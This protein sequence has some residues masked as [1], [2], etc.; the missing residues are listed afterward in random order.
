M[1]LAVSSVS[2]NSKNFASVIP[3]RFPVPS[4]VVKRQTACGLLLPSLEAPALRVPTVHL[5]VAVVVEDTA[6]P[7]IKQSTQ[8]ATSIN[9]H[10]VISALFPD[11]GRA[12]ILNSV[13][14]IGIY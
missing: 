14:C 6:P 5:G 3:L 13:I 4:A 2:T 11:K 8:P 7:A 1:N 12:F 10:E 9:K